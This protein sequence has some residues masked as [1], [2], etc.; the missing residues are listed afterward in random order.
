MSKI[1]EGQRE[2]STFKKPFGAPA[3]R[4]AGGSARDKR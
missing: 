3:K 4:K 1:R 2:E